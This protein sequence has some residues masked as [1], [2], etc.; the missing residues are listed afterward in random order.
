MENF[1]VKPVAPAIQSIGI[2]PTNLEGSNPPTTA[3]VDLE[4]TPNFDEYCAASTQKNGGI[5]YFQ[6]PSPQEMVKI[7]GL[8]PVVLESGKQALVAIFDIRDL[9][10]NRAHN[11]PTQLKAVLL[12]DSVADN[13]IRPEAEA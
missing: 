2:V 10:N 8:I 5:T 9:W 1:Y 7:I 12:P 4:R 11:S 6:A 13:H 3:H